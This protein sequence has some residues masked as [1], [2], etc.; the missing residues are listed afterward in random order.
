MLPNSCVGE[1]VGCKEWDGEITFGLKILAI[2]RPA[3]PDV[4]LRCSIRATFQTSRY[5]HI[6]CGSLSK[7]WSRLPYEIG[8]S[9][10]WKTIKPW[11]LNHQI[12]KIFFNRREQ[13]K[14]C[15]RRCC[16]LFGPKPTLAKADSHNSKLNITENHD[17]PFPPYCIC[18]LREIR[19][20]GFRFWWRLNGGQ[21]AIWC[22]L[23]GEH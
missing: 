4:N 19:N 22:R 1:T 6:S 21:W 20:L 12:E 9:L 10:H 11:F 16:C 5:F 15:E 23:I 14:L 7:S 3:K 13:Y 8:R 18:I 17:I 2:G